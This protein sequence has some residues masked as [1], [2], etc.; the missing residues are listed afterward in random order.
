PAALPI[1][2]PPPHRSIC[3][4][5]RSYSSPRSWHRRSAPRRACARSRARCLR[6]FP[7]SA[8]S[9]RSASHSRQSPA[10]GGSGG[11]LR[12]K[13]HGRGGRGG[14]LASRTPAPPDRARPGVVDTRR[15]RHGERR[16]LAYLRPRARRGAVARNTPRTG[17]GRARRQ[18]DPAD[19]HHRRADLGS[20]F[21]GT[22]RRAGLL[23][24]ALARAGLVL[25]RVDLLAVDPEAHLVF[26]N[27]QDVLPRDLCE[28]PS[29]E[30]ALQSGTGSDGHAH[31]V[32]GLL[33]EADVLDRTDA[34]PVAI[35]HRVAFLDRRPRPL[36]GVGERGIGGPEEGVGRD[37]VAE[38]RS[39]PTGRWSD[40]SVL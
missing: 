7:S 11:A 17:D 15:G 31:H 26:S 24:I 12:A 6:S 34:V 19:G 38:V 13:A 40:E 14:S 28:L 18:S 2:K 4:S 32:A 16:T 35:L 5:R 9:P 8:G 33:V 22:V 37:R 39:G 36:A 3:L 29:T 20:A 21:G 1:L 27:P 23:R 30:E 25:P 10:R